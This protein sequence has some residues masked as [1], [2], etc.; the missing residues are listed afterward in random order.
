L[1]ALIYPYW[2][3]AIKLVAAP[4]WQPQ[5]IKDIVFQGNPLLKYLEAFTKI[6]LSV[7]C[8]L[9]IIKDL[10]AEEIGE[11]TSKFKDFEVA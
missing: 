2:Y 8:L 11:L 5:Y 7:L 6:Q 1:L 3:I 10:P 9:D 4:D